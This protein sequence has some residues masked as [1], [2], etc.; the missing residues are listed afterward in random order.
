MRKRW[1]RS[2]VRNLV[3]PI[4]ESMPF[5]RYSYDAL[6]VEVIRKLDA[7]ALYKP[8]YLVICDERFPSYMS[9]SRICR[10][11]KE[12]NPELKADDD[13]EA[14]KEILEQDWRDWARG[15]FT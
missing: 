15:R 4:L 13:V 8:F 3:T 5:T 9:V 6:Y 12:N 2:E 1:K 11:I 10:K 7:S 14:C